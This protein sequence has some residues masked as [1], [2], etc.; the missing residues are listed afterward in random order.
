MKTK[1]IISITLITSLLL[2]TP[3]ISAI[4]NQPNQK[5][6]KTKTNI[7]HYIRNI[8]NIIDEPPQNF[9][10]FYFL[11][12]ISLNIRIIFVSNLAITPGD[13]FWGDIDIKRPFFALILITL[14]W[15]FAFWYNFFDKI[16]EKNNW[17]LP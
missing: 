17:E 2:L 10:I 1:T 8:K 5:N 14:Y 13:D 4:Q 16:A 7:N 3:T 6:N 11:I 12:M 15:R 9:L